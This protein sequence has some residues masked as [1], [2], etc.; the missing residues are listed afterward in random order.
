MVKMRSVFLRDDIHFFFVLV[1]GFAMTND[2]DPY[3]R[4]LFVFVL[5][6]RNRKKV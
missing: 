3:L 5:A 1:K 4:G 2:A 6:D